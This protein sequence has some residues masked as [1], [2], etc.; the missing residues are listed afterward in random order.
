[1]IE[2]SLAFFSLE[3]PRGWWLLGALWLSLSLLA[4][5]VVRSASDAAT[6]WLAACALAGAG[7]AWALAHGQWSA[8]KAGGLYASAGVGALFVLT[9]RIPGTLWALFNETYSILL[10]WLYKEEINLSG[11]GGYFLEI[12]A[13]M[14]GLLAR[15]GQWLAAFL[16]G[17]SL[18]DPVIG[19]L[20]WLVLFWVLAGWAGWMLARQA[21]VLG[22][23][24]PMLAIQALVMK[25]YRQAE[26]SLL[27]ANLF[28]FVALLGL[29][30]YATR[31]RE[32]LRTGLDYAENATINSVV[33]TLAL[34]ALLVGLAGAIP[35]ISIEE[36]QRAIEERRAAQA[37]ASGASGTP[38]AGG[39]SPANTSGERI[40]AGLPRDHLLRGDVTLTETLVMQVRTYDFPPMPRA[41]VQL[42]APRYY[43]RAETYDIYSGQGWVSSPVEQ[44]SYPA[45][46]IFVA[47]KPEFYRRVQHD[48]EIYNQE[49]PPV[50]R[51]GILESTDVPLDIEWRNVLARLTLPGAPNGSA[52][53][54]RATS[55]VNTYQ[56]TSQMATVDVETLRDIWPDYPEW[57]R[58]RYLALPPL[59]E[60][61]TAL[62]HDIT[63]TAPSLYD[64]AE[65]IERYL[66]TNYEYSLDIPAPPSGRDPVD[67][68]L[69]DLGEGYCDYYASAMVVLARASGIPARLVVGYVGGAYDPVDAVYTVREA[70]AHSWVEVYFPQIGWVEFEP[71]A[72]QP[73]FQRV[74]TGAAALPYVPPDRTRNPWA[75]LV[76]WLSGLPVFLPWAGLALLLAGLAFG[77]YRFAREW[78]DPRPRSI[79]QIGRV[80]SAMQARG[81]KMLKLE[82]RES[83]TPQ[84]FAEALKQRLNTDVSQ[85]RAQKNYEAISDVEKI[86][87][88]YQ[89][90]VFSERLPGAAEAREAS[91]AWRRLRWRL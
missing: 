45:G 74:S 18:E 40:V 14:S 62:A 49:K 50:F 31:L 44:A 68:F 38:V 23:F 9:A 86:A 80:Y 19:G 84:E 12:Q 75:G 76:G 61:V 25:S 64:R 91:R 26:T 11:L 34:A 46:E 1:M 54:F 72:S 58:T 7:T 41:E 24:L 63:A 60:R 81:L 90:S 39:S 67:Y 78:R 43:W 10:A 65:A 16:Q 13:R 28:I 79:R 83:Q 4:A 27:W 42:N 36:I 71:T 53:L 33:S 88:L 51:V 2:R 59:P 3:N 17:R 70:N 87:G 73:G 37:R 47:E 77:I 85:A 55:P 82:L 69:F 20:M 48:F 5:E 6:A 32:W 15:A 56:A 66:R 35:S 57:V 52:D 8:A 29:S 22:A 21:S 30:L 89:L